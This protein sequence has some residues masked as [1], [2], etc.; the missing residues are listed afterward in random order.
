M[1]RGLMALAILAVSTWMAAGEAAGAAESPPVHSARATATLVSEA[2]SVA[3]GKTLR[4]GLHLAMA[5]GW[6]TYWRN[7]GDAG[8]APELTW[9]LPA[10][11]TAGATAWPAPARQQEGPLVTYGYSGDLLLPVTITGA[12]GPLALQLHAEWLICA[13]I[14]VPE[15]G[16]FRLD[17]PAGI[18][19]PSAQ[20][21]LFAAADQRTPRPSPWPARIAADG[22]LFVPGLDGVQDAWFAP[23]ATGATE[24]AAPQTV[25]SVAGGLRLTQKPGPEF[26]AGSPL[27]GVL[28]VR[29]AGGQESALALEA[30]PGEAPAIA[31][32]PGLWRL[33]GLALL[34]GLI[35]NLMPCVLPVLAVK[36][37]GLA[38]LSGA[39]ERAAA[40][41]AASYTAGVLAAFAALGGAL[42]ALRAAG[43][44]AGWGF[45]FQSPEFVA[46][47]AWVL[48]AVGLNLSG[49][50]EVTGGRF[51]GV[52][53]SLAAREGHAGSF[54]T[55]LL[56]VLVATPCTAPFMGAAVA[57]ALAAPP[58]TA[59]AVFLAMGLGLAAPYA[60]MALVPGVARA[61]PRP[62]RWMDVMKQALA[63]PMYGAAVWL[64]W[65][66]SAQSGPDGALVTLGGV[67]LLGFAGWALGLAQRLAHGGGR[68]GRGAARVVAAAAVFGA[69]ALLPGLAGT[70]GPLAPQARAEDGTEPFSAARLVALQAEHR[71]VFVDMTAAW[72]V[73]CLVNERLAL[74]P[75]TVRRAFV[76]RHVVYMKG[77]WT[78]QDP[79]IT[80][81][82]RS[83][84]RDGVPLYVFYPGD[85]AAP[86][87]LPQILTEGI[88]LQ[89][90]GAAES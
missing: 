21:G 50:F 85:G 35:L 24:P 73:T 46:I 59:M 6:H 9:T 81:F 66:A 80:A 3:A 52:G 84:A 89:A 28:T 16:D 47:T 74:A 42:L 15:S 18:G 41:H 8:V 51:T 26:H 61:L 86:S 48:F 65:V 33:L 23:D 70:T 79:E 1:R 63:F 31:D 43:G 87:V 82:L 12:A 5:P 13:K 83:H 62:G 67:L 58:A 71:P 40:W 56:A 32:A 17:L 60:A 78:R 19:A 22:T 72:C 38:G 57:G 45:Q 69:L 53:Q 55:G 25:T 36:T 27:A 75:E 11:A 77:D 64:V 39:R 76:D 68:R 49:V 10:G 37:V 44:A 29:D 2:D 14:C 7:P 88:V 4:V 20:A 90:I 34:G 54:F 30:T